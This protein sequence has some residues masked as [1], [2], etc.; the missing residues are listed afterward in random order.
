[1]VLIVLS[2][3]FISRHVN[4]KAIDNWGTKIFISSMREYKT[5]KSTKIVVFKKNP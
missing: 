2:S 5:T 1:M 3:L 4:D